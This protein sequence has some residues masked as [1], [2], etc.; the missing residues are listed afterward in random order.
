VGHGNL[1]LW[2]VLPKVTQ[3][4]WRASRKKHIGGE[5]LGLPPGQLRGD[6]SHQTLACCL[7]PGAHAVPETLQLGLGRLA[8]GFLRFAQ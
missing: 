4:G 5:A 6:G 7:L 3:V 1:R 2:H 8:P